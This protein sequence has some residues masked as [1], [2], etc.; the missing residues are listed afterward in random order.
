MS[1]GLSGNVMH[2]ISLASKNSGASFNK[3]RVILIYFQF[4]AFLIQ[5]TPCITTVTCITMRRKATRKKGRERKRN[6]GKKEKG[7]WKKNKEIGR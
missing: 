5:A 6:K 1:P 2:M 3:K 4:L 7:E